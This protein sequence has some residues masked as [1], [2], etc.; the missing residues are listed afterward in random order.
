MSII[1]E[2]Y[3]NSEAL[4]PTAYKYITRKKLKINK[5]RTENSQFFF[6][7]N[8]QKNVFKYIK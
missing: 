6:E 1:I 2:K 3:I 5:M 8:Q 7:N 4:H